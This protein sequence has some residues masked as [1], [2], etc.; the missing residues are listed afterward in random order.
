MPLLVRVRKAQRWTLPR[1]LTP[2]SD[3]WSF[4]G[5]DLR[6]CHLLLFR[7]RLAR[8]GA[9]EAEDSGNIRQGSYPFKTIQ[10]INTVEINGKQTSRKFNWWDTEWG[11]G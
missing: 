10:K 8:S 4:D 11:G 2:P 3:S 6:H 9:G 1:T 7:R 5:G